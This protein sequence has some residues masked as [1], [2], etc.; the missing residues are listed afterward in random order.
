MDKQLENF[1]QAA[2]E[3]G[4][5]LPRQPVEF[6]LVTMKLLEEIYARASVA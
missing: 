3:V 2:Q 6:G 5:S 4:I 1:V